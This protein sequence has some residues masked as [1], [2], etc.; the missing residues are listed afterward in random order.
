VQPGWF[1]I[2]AF[3]V[4]CVIFYGIGSL[5]DPRANARLAMRRRSDE[6]AGWDGPKEYDPE[7]RRAI[8]DN[9]VKKELSGEKDWYQ[10]YKSVLDR[11]GITELEIKRQIEL[12][13]LPPTPPADS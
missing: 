9:M 2:L 7:H 1:A 12:R 3:F 13:G 8:V 6:R 11:E 5:L 4:T 10:T